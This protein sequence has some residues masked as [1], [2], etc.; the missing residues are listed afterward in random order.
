MIGARAGDA[1]LPFAS[2]PLADSL[3]DGCS[4]LVSLASRAFSGG[5]APWRPDRSARSA[6]GTRRTDRSL[7]DYT[8]ALKSRFLRSAEPL[9]VPWIAA[10][11]GLSPPNLDSQFDAAFRGQDVDYGVERFLNDQ[12]GLDFE[13]SSSSAIVA[14]AE[15]IRACGVWPFAAES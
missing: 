7:Y 8:Q 10:L 9:A 2:G 12:L 15:T 3:R 1:R 14:A 13:Q 11:P 5:Q 6:P 4:S